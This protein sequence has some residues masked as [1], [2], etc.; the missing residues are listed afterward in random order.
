VS[1]HQSKRTRKPP[2]TDIHNTTNNNT[3]MSNRRIS[4]SW[5]KISLSIQIKVTK[6]PPTNLI[7]TQINPKP[8]KETPK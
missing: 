4:N 2:E 3:H 8:K 5:L 7:E 6:N 1:N